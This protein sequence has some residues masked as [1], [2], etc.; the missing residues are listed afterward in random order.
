MRP[1]QDTRTTPDGQKLL[2]E[3]LL[4]NHDALDL[5]GAFVDLGGPSQPSSW[6]YPVPLSW[7]DSPARVGS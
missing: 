1:K 7:D 3:Q 4:C 2:A 5:V 6:W